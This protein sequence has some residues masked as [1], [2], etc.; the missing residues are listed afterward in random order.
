MIVTVKDGIRH[1][2]PLVQ[3]SRSEVFSLVTF[4]VG[5]RSKMKC[6]AHD[7]GYSAEDSLGVSNFD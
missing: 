1:S 6:A 3:D 2:R 4:F 5:A 7:I